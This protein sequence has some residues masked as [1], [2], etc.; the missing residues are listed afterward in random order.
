MVGNTVSEC[1]MCGVKLSDGCRGTY[2]SN[3]LTMNDGPGM[4]VE[5]ENAIPVCVNQNKV[6][7]G[8]GV[9]L[10]LTQQCK[11]HF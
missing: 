3:I 10:L 6:V 8:K 7:G 2:T 4:C 1:S 11:G 9:G 5:G